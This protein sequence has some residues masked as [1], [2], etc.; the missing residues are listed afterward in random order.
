MG[1]VDRDVAAALW[2]GQIAERKRK[3]AQSRRQEEAERKRREAERQRQQAERQRQEAERKRQEEAERKRRAAEERLEVEAQRRRRWPELLCD[4]ACEDNEAVIER[5]VAEG[6]SPNAKKQGLIRKWRLFVA[7][8][9]T[10]NSQNWMVVR[11]WRPPGTHPGV[12]RVEEWPPA[13]PSLEDE[14]ETDSTPVA[15]EIF[16]PAPAAP[17]DRLARPPRDSQL[18]KTS[19]ETSC[20]MITLPLFVESW[21]ARQ[22]G[23]VFFTSCGGFCTCS[24]TALRGS[25]IGEGPGA[26]DRRPHD[27]RGKR[28]CRGPGAD[29]QPPPSAGA[30]LRKIPA[31]ARAPLR[32]AAASRRR[33]QLAA[34]AAAG[35]AGTASRLRSS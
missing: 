6:A 21:R 23:G 2:A 17:A 19:H 29:C 33:P 34:R 27:G 5:L 16:S 18:L 35:S 11:K 9:M 32:P 4:A 13:S 8:R 3:E 14:R 26:P 7:G 30:V 10:V 28:P 22:F 15:G 20:R 31:A 12:S 1:A 24:C 25:S